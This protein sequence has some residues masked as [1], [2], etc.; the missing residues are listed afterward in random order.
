MSHGLTPCGAA[1]GR[2][3]EEVVSLMDPRYP[4]TAGIISRLAGV[5][6][7]APLFTTT[8]TVTS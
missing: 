3:W 5:L 1:A 7:K 4:S 6:W 8:A 2:D